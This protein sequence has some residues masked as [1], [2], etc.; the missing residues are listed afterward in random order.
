M[1]SVST[2]NTNPFSIL[3]SSP[4]HSPTNESLIKKNYNN[5]PIFSLVQEN[6]VYE[7]EQ[8]NNTPKKMLWSDE[9]E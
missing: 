2:N 7:K 4:T 8:V 9:C 1:N 5:I 3:K 6:P